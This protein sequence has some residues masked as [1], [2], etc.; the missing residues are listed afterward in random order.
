V[1]NV[2]QCVAVIVGQHFGST[3]WPSRWVG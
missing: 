3:A 1:W 2:T